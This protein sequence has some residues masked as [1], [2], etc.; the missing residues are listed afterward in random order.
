MKVL[1]VDAG[2][3][4]NAIAHA[5]SRSEQVKEIYIAPGNGGSEFFEKCKIAELDGKKIP[6]IRAID[7]IVRFAKKCE[8]DL[9]YIGPEE[10]LSLGLVDRLEEEGIPAVGPKKEA[11]ILEASKCWAKDFLKRIGVPIPE[12]ANFDNP[13][14]AKEYIREKFNNGIVVKA[15]GLAAG[16]GVY[17]CDSVEEALR[18]VDEIMVQKKFGEAGNRIVVEERLRGIEVA[19]TAMTD[20]KTVKPFGH[21]RD[22]KRAFDSDDIEGLRD[23]Y[24]GLTKKF[25]TK[26]QIEQLYREGKLINPNTG[27]MGAVSPHPA[28]TEEVEQRIMEMVVEPIIENFDKEFKGVLYPVIMLVEENGELIPKVLEINVRDC[29]P[30]AEAKLP[31]LK[32]DMA[33]ISMAVVEGRLDEVEMRFS[34]D[35]CVAVC[36]VSG[37]L[38][39]REGLKPGYPAD[40]YTSQPIT[41]IEEAMKE[42]I[43]YANGIAKTNGYV[44]TGGRVLTVVGMGQS[45]EEARSK[46][47]S[48]LEKISFPGMRYRRT[49]GLDVPE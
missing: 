22:Y 48:A 15:D 41:G 34:S 24:I 3:R 4:G 1:V 20:G 43:I 33:E 2:G 13:E 18:A 10:P 8:V 9:A 16:K 40:H 35:Y 7:E 29:D 17:V 27:G 38:K 14:E 6:S 19:F 25:Y 30:G 12:Y 5:F 21:A 36:A 46:A 37:A 11:T 32:S 45:I 39:G 42:A 49:I 31:R 26:A 47:Y 23:F 28:V 44:T